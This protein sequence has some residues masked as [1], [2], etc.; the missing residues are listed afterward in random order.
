MSR[1]RSDSARGSGKSISVDS[2]LNS[3]YNSDV[4][5]SAYF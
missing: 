4:A 3:L 5:T 1:R 2:G